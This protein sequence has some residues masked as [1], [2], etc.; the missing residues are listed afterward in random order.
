MRRKNPRVQLFIGTLTYN[1]GE[2][3]DLSVD[4]LFRLHEKFTSFL[5]ADR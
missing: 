2:M 5:R 1:T 4:Q 3:K